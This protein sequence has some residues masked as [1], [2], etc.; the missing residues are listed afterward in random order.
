[1]ASTVDNRATGEK[2]PIAMERRPILVKFNIDFTDTDNQ[3]DQNET[4][5]LGTL[6]AG[7]IVLASY[8][9]VT[10]ADATISDVDLG[11]STDGATNAGFIEAAD[12]TTTGVKAGAVAL[13]PV[14]F[15]AEN[16]IVFT[17]NDAQTID[18]A[19]VEVYLLVVKKTP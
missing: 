7:D 15:T 8:I 5:S 17:N 19:V 12:I 2:L 9:N 11:Y 1:M 16:Q 14:I 18:E 4:M 13:Y 6:E 3:L 10:T